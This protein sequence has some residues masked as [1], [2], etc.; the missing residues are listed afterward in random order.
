[1][2]QIIH[3]IIILI[4]LVIL[5][6]NYQPKIK[7]IEN[8]EKSNIS[9]NNLK[10]KNNLY[11]EFLKL[12]IENKEEFYIKGREYLMSLNGKKYNDSNIIT[13]QDKLNYLLIHESPENK[14]E[15]VDKILLRNY[16]KKILGEDI[17]APIIKIYKTPDDINLEELPEKFVLKCNHGSQMNIICKDK[18]K[19]DLDNAKKQLRNWMNMNYGLINFEYQY[20][21]VNK[22][23]FVEKYLGDG[24]VDYKINCYNGVPHHI[25]V[26]KHINGKNVN[27]FYN[28]NWTLTEIKFKYKNYIRDPSV[29]IPKPKNLQKMLNYSK[30]LSSNFCY[31]RVDLYEINDTVYLGEL[32][33]SPANNLMDYNDQRM[34]I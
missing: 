16:S 31:C 14:T 3:K 11:K 20:M 15:I 7:K 29:I 6:N 9:K 4:L 2:Q 10:A 8:L 34:R 30:I 26:K 22:K 23:I 12:Y 27:N 17:C 33:F 25:R 19:F 24:I 1:M 18:K 21:N 5:I 32:T 13:I 28:I